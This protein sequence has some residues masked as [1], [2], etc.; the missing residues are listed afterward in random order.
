MYRQNNT[1]MII[2]NNHLPN[3]KMSQPVFILQL[4]TKYIKRQTLTT[5]VW[6]LS[7][8]HL[9]SECQGRWQ[10]GSSVNSCNHR[11]IHHAEQHAWL[12]FVEDGPL[13][14]WLYVCGCWKLNR[15]PIKTPWIERV[16]AFLVW[17]ESFFPRVPHLTDDIWFLSTWLHITD[18]FSLNLTMQA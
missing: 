6:Q 8:V 11:L 18:S 13:L 4:D 14:L 5:S 7:Y 15:G 17:V 12:L 16:T 1:S 2:S 9:H 10:V 3:K